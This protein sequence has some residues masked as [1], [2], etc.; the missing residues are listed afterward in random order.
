MSTLWNHG[1][2][3][4]LC[5]IFNLFVVYFYSITEYIS[6]GTANEADAPEKGRL[7]T[8]GGAHRGVRLCDAHPVHQRPHRRCGLDGVPAGGVFCFHVHRRLLVGRGRFCH[9][10]AGGQLR[11]PH[12]LLCLQLHHPGEHLLRRGDAGGL[13]YDEHPDHPRQ[14]AGAAADGERD[15]EDAGQPPAGC[16]PRPAH[17]ADVHLRGLLYGHRQL[18]LGAGSRR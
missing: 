11:V 17:S 7:G 9:Q 10:R 14:K 2:M 4:T 12:A 16:L 1:K 13:L 6:G 3:P 15:G 18:R 5:C 8:F